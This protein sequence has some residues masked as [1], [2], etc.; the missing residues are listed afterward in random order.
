MVV[1]VLALVAVGAGYALAQRSD[2]PPTTSPSICDYST[3]G[4]L[5]YP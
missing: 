4:N 1:I 2:E 3:C 5:V